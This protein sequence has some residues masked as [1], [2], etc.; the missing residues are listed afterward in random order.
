M[1]GAVSTFYVYF[2][3]CHASETGT[4]RCCSKKATSAS[5]KRATKC[6]A[7]EGWI[8]ENL[9]EAQGIIIEGNFIKLNRKFIPS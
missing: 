4:V 3:H 6:I 1:A 2:L 7:A 5:H 9:L 8:F